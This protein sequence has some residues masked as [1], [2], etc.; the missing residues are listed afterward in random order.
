MVV[1]LLVVAVA[2]PVEKVMLLCTRR[3]LLGGVS[4]VASG[5]RFKSGWPRTAAITQPIKTPFKK[6]R[7]RWLFFFL[8][9]ISIEANFEFLLA[10]KPT[11]GS[12]YVF[13]GQAP[14]ALLI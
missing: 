7:R 4:V 11:K 6:E 3:I 13:L 10:H 1:V 5:C 9:S 2:V 14:L 12:K 8:P